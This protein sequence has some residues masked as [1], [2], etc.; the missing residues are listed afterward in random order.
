MGTITIQLDRK[1]EREL[2]RMAKITGRPKSELAYDALRKYFALQRFRKLRHQ[3]MPY[4]RMAGYLADE[5]VFRDV[6]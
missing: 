1:L 5:D 4:A 2:A 3:T 6:S